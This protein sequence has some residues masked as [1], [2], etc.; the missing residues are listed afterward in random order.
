MFNAMGGI[1]AVIQGRNQGNP[2]MI[3]TGVYP[4]KFAGQKTAGKTVT[5]SWAKSC[6]AKIRYRLIGVFNHT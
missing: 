1:N 2:D 3:D 6:W 4:V 5:F